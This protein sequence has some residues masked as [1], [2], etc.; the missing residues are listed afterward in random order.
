MAN[1]SPKF[2]KE[3]VEGLCYHRLKNVISYVDNYIKYSCT[4]KTNTKLRYLGYRQLSPKDEIKLLINKNN[5]AI[6][7]IAEN[8]I[9]PIELIFQYGDE[10]NNKF[11]WENL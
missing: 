7:D 5:K 6:F 10:I 4:H 9:F 3:M 11:V 2:N 1:D 8:D